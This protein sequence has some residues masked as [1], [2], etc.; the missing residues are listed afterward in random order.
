[1][2]LLGDCDMLPID[3]F[4]ELFQHTTTAR[5]KPRLNQTVP[6]RNVPNY[7]KPYRTVRANVRAENENTN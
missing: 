3:V 2:P 4:N 6:Y 5:W 7:G 1:M